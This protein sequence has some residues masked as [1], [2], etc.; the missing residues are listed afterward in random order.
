MFIIEYYFSIMITRNT[1]QYL[2]EDILII[3]RYF[4]FSS[5]FIFFIISQQTL[6]HIETSRVVYVIL[7]FMLYWDF[8]CHVLHQHVTVRQ[9]TARYP[10]VDYSA[11]YYFC[12]FFPYFTVAI[13][14]FSCCTFFIMHHFHVALFCVAIILCYTFFMYCT[15]SCCTFLHVAK[16]SFCIL[17]LLHS[18]CVAV[19]SFSCHTISISVARTPTN[20]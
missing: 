4:T 20:I 13:Y 1:Q 3:S 12:T 11:V 17:L 16:F 10:F 5:S 9:R 7:E 15:I 14:I 6:I 19:F 8:L 2:K 18:S